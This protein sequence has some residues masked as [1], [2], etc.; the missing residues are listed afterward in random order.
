MTPGRLPRPSVYRPCCRHH[1]R[2]IVPRV[3][4]P[5]MTIYRAA[6]EG[7]RYSADPATPCRYQTVARAL[8]PNLPKFS[9]LFAVYLFPKFHENQR[10]RRSKQYL[11][12]PLAEV[13]TESSPT[14]V[15]SWPLKWLFKPAYSQQSSVNSYWKQTPGR[16][17]SATGSLS[18]GFA[19]I[20]AETY[21]VQQ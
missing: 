4:I 2:A 1:L 6:L 9:Q 13:I 19:W 7:T 11:L 3:N 16:Q 21:L 12:P 10:K 15:Y 20:P 18:Y 17:V 8:N 14:S 5:T